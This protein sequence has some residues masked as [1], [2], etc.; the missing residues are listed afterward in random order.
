MYKNVILLLNVKWAILSM[1]VRV[2]LEDKTSGMVNLEWTA[3]VKGLN[4]TNPSA[5]I[6]STQSSQR[7]NF[8]R[9]HTVSSM[10]QVSRDHVAEMCKAQLLSG[11][12]PV[13]KRNRGCTFKEIMKTL[14]ERFGQAV[15]DASMCGRARIW[16]E[17]G[18]R[19]QYW[20]SQ[21]L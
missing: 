19:R 8:G 1:S 20:S 7:V 5:G 13:V 2:C 3:S 17:V 15:S 12:K 10:D 14:E 18:A 16:P 4:T 21:F 11:I 6:N 9:S